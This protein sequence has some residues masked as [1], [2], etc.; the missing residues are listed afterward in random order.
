MRN[1]KPTQPWCHPKRQ[2]IH[3][4]RLYGHRCHAFNLN[5]RELK[6]EGYRLI[7]IPI[8]LPLR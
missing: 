6:R 1:R 4:M 7:T 2:S 3:L 5:S 8:T